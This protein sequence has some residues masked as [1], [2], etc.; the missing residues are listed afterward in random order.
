MLAGGVLAAC[1]ALVS[2]T[3]QVPAEHDGQDDREQSDQ[4][5]GHDGSVPHLGADVIEVL[6]HDPHA[7]TEG[8]EIAGGE[9]Y[10]S[11]GRYGSSTLRAEDPATGAVRRQAALPDQFFGEGT[12]VVGDRVWQLTYREGVAIQRDRTSLQ[13]LGRARFSGE[14]WGLCHEDAGHEDAGHEDPGHAEPGG[15]ARLISSDGT[16]QLTMRDPTTFAATGRITAHRPGGRPVAHLNELEC[17]G[18]QVW[19]NLYGSDEIVR[20]DPASGVIT[21]VVDASRL[22]PPEQRERLDVLNGIAAVPGTDEF[23]LAGKEWPSTFRVRFR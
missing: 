16:A 20:I 4:G 23:L 7:F 18:G 15:K 12:T 9:L 1:F 2:C 6:P 10:E 5:V 17:A 8:L 14:G 13:E 21:A 22:L 19:A 3:P 11:T